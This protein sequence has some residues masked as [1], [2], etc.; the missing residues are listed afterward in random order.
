MK[1]N[2]EFYKLPSERASAALVASNTTRQNLNSVI[3]AQE[4]TSLF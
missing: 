1:A 4:I 2:A 3:K